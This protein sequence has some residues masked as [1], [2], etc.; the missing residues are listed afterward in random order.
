MGWIASVANGAYCVWVG[1]G[2][3][4]VCVELCRCWRSE[5]RD[6]R[7]R[8]S[9]RERERDERDERERRERV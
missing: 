8:E 3:V 4:M 2:R 9:E 6:E 5:V 1:C 7:E